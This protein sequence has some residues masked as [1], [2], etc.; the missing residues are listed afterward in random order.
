MSRTNTWFRLYLVVISLAIGV[1][2]G[3][4]A[5]AQEAH[6]HTPRVSGMPEG[7]PLF[8][9]QPTVTSVATGG[10][11]NPKTWST[12]KVPAANDKVAIA[13]GHRVTYDLVSNDTIE[14]VEVRGELTFAADANKRMKVGTLTVLEAGVLEIGGAAH[15]VAT[16]H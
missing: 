10:W 3:A 12:N 2:P 1:G 13:A 11:S 5:S 4:P 15:P 14:C 7:L 6:P 8:C 16:A 9:A